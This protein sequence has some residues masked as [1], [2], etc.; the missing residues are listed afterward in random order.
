M[1]DFLEDILEAEFYTNF[2]DGSTERV[3]LVSPVLFLCL[4]VIAAAAAVVTTVLLF[5]IG[6]AF[7]GGALCWFDVFFGLFF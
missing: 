6:T 3:S 7:A 2:E 1:A 4:A 5:C